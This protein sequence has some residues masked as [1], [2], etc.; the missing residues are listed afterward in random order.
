MLVPSA[1][2]RSFNDYFQIVTIEGISDDDCRRFCDASV[3]NQSLYHCRQLQL[4]VSDKRH[5]WHKKA[6]FKVDKTSVKNTKPEKS[7]EPFEENC[8]AIKSIESRDSLK[9]HDQPQTLQCTDQYYSYR[10]K[11]LMTSIF[12]NCFYIVITAVFYVIKSPPNI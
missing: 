2:R 1:R 7:M 8:T 12:L 9:K 4:M 10:G 11:L 5:C 6:H 3:V